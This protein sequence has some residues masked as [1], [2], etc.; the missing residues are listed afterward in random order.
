MAGLA[1]LD[2][3]PALALGAFQKLTI[4]VTPWNR[5]TG[6]V[7]YSQF[8]QIGRNAEY[9]MVGSGSS[10]GRRKREHT[11][12]GLA[13]LTPV[14]REGFVSNTSDRS[15]FALTVGRGDSLEI[16]SIDFRIDP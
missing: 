10:K 4:N 11:S 5:F 16:I 9:R 6:A 12:R 8:F 1:P 7:G 2:S 15:L 3:A 14:S 13:L